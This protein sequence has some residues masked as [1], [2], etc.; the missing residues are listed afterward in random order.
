MLPS[1]LR[2]LVSAAALACAATAP[3]HA[4]IGWQ[5]NL[6]G[7]SDSLNV[8]TDGT[9]VGGTAANDK[10]NI[11][12]VIVTNASAFGPAFNGLSALGGGLVLGTNG[13]P[14]PAGNYIYWHGTGNRFEINDGN[15]AGSD[16]GGNDL[17]V[18]FASA[19]HRGYNLMSWLGGGPNQVFAVDGMFAIAGGALAPDALQPAAVP[20]PAALLLS[21]TALAA[22]LATTRRRPRA[23][24]H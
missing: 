10:D 4:N 11:L 8:I 6:P 1:R 9:L 21:A 12:D 17:S 24:G 3:A 22:L 18:R 20:E 14:S 16:A 15:P 13:G 19:Q 2:A 5:F 7:A 23:G